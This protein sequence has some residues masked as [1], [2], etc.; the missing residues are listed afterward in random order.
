MQSIIILLAALTAMAPL[1][2]DAYLPAMPTMAS[3][4]DRPIHDVE[5]S[6]SVFLA[7][8]AL[9]Q[10]LGGPLSDRLGRRRIIFTGISFFSLGSLGIILSDS[11]T[12]IWLWRVLQALGGGMAI[13]NSAAV[14]RDISS[15]RE[16]ARYLSQMAIIMMIAPL[17]APMIGMVLLHL[18]GWRAIFLFLLIYGVVLGLLLFRFLPETR[19]QLTVG[20]A[21]QRY[22]SV[23]RH[24][25]AMGFLVAQ[26]FAYGSL[27]TF[28]TASPGVYM[29]FFGVSET[30][31]P[32]L[33]GANVII[34][35][36]ANR[37]NMQLLNYFSP[38]QLLNRGQLLQLSIG[39]LLLAYVWWADTQL[40]FVVVLGIMLFIGFQGLIVA[41]AIA[42]TVEFFPESAATAT[43]LLGACGFLTGAASG[44]LVTTLSDGSALPMI[45]VMTLCALSGWFL[46]TLIQSTGK[47]LHNFSPD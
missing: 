20:N 41:N 18:A 28:I 10:L 33:F 15:G 40:L 17:L 42:S 46:K 25:Q 16:S 34:M 22:L 31:Y 35:I 36:A 45:F 11:M 43:A 29:N 13:V 21:L 7:G 27:F 19:Q 5:I 38:P 23:L 30:L 39:S 32:F 8:F 6:L 4:L 9:G 14:I 1:A 3:Q 24:R 44:W 12:S 2:I 26:C 37:L 47:S